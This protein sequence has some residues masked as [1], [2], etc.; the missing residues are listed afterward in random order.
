LPFRQEFGKK[1]LL[2]R[3]CSVPELRGQEMNTNDADDME[4]INSQF[5]GLNLADESDINRVSPQIQLL[6]SGLSSE[7]LQPLLLTICSASV[8]VSMLSKR[9]YLLLQTRKYLRLLT[10]TLLPDDNP[11]KE[12]LCA[13]FNKRPKEVNYIPI[14][15]L[16]RM[17]FYF[18][19][20][21]DP[22]LE[23][24][25]R[26]INDYLCNNGELTTR[27]YEVISQIPYINETPKSADR[28]NN[29]IAKVGGTKPKEIFYS[30]LR[31][32]CPGLESQISYHQQI[33][34]DD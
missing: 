4:L 25:Y 12:V 27:F 9:S 24:S 5:D 33:R 11:D 30:D 16:T 1:I 29:N 17:L 21:K 3:C 6:L 28:N 22:L 10:S 15:Y 32:I 8:L 23:I 7:K 20:W 2:D 18:N 26:P 19:L 13:V 34:S 14:Q 31:N